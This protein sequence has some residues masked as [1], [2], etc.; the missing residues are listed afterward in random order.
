MTPHLL[1]EYIPLL[2][3]AVRMSR[4]LM[5]FIEDDDNMRDYDRQ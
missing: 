5:K 3:E 4:K 1:E 2:E